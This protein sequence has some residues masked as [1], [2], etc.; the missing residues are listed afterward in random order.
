V[1]PS[2]HHH[3][4]GAVI[5]ANLAKDLAA[6]LDAASPKPP[7]AGSPAIGLLAGGSGF[8]NVKM[9]GGTTGRVFLS[10]GNPVVGSFTHLIAA[11][12]T[13]TDVTAF[14]APS[15]GY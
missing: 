1:I 10:A 14:F 4:A 15:S 12:S 11:G 13:A 8:V 3:Y 7:H 2:L 6:V 9:S 5:D